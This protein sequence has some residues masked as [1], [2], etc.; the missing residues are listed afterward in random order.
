MKSFVA[1]ATTDRIRP[2][3]RCIF[4]RQNSRHSQSVEHIVP[5]SLGDR[6]HVLPR[7]IVCDG[8][9]NYFSR[10]VEQP[11]LESAAIRVLRF[12]QELESRRGRIPPIEGT[13][14]PDI[15][16]TVVRDFKTGTLSAD[17]PLDAYE[18][19]TAMEKGMLLLPIGGAPPADPVISR[20]LAKVGLEAIAFN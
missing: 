16:T 1:C 20:F 10:K 2:A 13:F 19:L 8:C 5:Y 11:F 18:R 9:N 17:I 6:S 7:G 15:P 4:C 14:W 3:L 12:H